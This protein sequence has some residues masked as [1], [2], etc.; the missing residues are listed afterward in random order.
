M[1][2][3]PE[4]AIIERRERSILLWSVSD[5]LSTPLTKHKIHDIMQDQKEER[6]FPGSLPTLI[7]ANPKLPYIVI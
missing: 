3:V 1:R 5:P 7:K 4:L 6:L 2:L